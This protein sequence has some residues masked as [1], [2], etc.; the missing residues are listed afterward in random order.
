M[1]ALPCHP[2]PAACMCP[3][4]RETVPSPGRSRTGTAAGSCDRGRSGGF[5]LGSGASEKQTGWGNFTPPPKGT[6]RRPGSHLERGCLS[7]VRAHA[8]QGW[9]RCSCHS[10][11]SGR[12]Q[13]SVSSLG[14]P[15][16]WPKTTPRSTAPTSQ[17]KRGL[18][19]EWPASSVWS[20]WPHLRRCAVS[21]A[22]AAGLF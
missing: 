17:L 22:S 9:H 6:R 5:S 21:W 7:T 11:G 15:C 10:S 14:T 16:C 8:S 1:V 2:A 12:E 20:R 18:L 3:Y 19:V 13:V 4:R